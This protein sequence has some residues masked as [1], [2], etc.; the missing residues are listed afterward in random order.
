MSP[1]AD[2]RRTGPRPRASS[3]GEA[4]DERRVVQLG[5]GQAWPSPS[6]AEARA[7]R[8]PRRR[9]PASI[10][11]LSRRKLADPV[12]ACPEATSSR[13]QAPK[14][15]RRISR[16]MIDSRSCAS[17]S[18]I[19][20][21]MSR[22]TRN[23]ID[24]E[25]LHPREELVEVG[26]DELLERQEVARARPRRGACG[27]ERSPSGHE[28]RQDLRDLD[29]R[30]L[31]LLR[32]PGPRASTASESDRLERNG[33]GCPGSTASGVSTGKTERAEVGPRPLLG[34][35]VEQALPVADPDAAPRPAP[36]AAPRPA[37]PCAVLELPADDLAR[38]G[39]AARAGVRPSG[40]AST[41]GLLELVV[42]PRDPDHEELV[43]VGEVDG[44]ELEPLEQRP[45]RVARLVEHPLVE[46]QPGHLA[47]EV[48]RGLLGRR[49]GAVGAAF[50]ARHRKT[51][52]LAFRGRQQ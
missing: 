50:R 40:L 20:M 16:S 46:G 32:S 26:G 42:Q 39:P 52:V 35:G 5:A 23:G 19:S 21:S 28:A 15:R 31:A 34:L 8:T 3:R 41:S 2:E 48:E 14:R 6:A 29:P 22:V 36:G 18:R 7:A 17:S 24:P 13:T 27:P 1:C 51:V 38:C 49:S 43:Q 12:A 37:A 4:R 10:S 25:D 9:P 30:E 33:N 44:Q 47:V 45:A 11:S